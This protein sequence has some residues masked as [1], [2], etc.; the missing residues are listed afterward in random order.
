MSLAAGRH[1][2]DRQMSHIGQTCQN[3]PSQASRRYFCAPHVPKL[4]FIVWQKIV[5]AQRLLSSFFP[6]LT[7]YSKSA[8]P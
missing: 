1:H 6:V 3:Y 2:R 8:S 7:H 5:L 4:T